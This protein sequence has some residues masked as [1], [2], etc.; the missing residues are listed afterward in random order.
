[1]SNLAERLNFSDRPE[2]DDAILVKKGDFSEMLG[3]LHHHIEA[4][5]FH[6]NTEE[7]MAAAEVMSTYGAT[8]PSS[9]HFYFWVD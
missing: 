9:D 1:M 7:I 5:E 8:D 3:V 6:Y 2:N 4:I